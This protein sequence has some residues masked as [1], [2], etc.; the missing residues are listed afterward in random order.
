MSSNGDGSEVNSRLLSK[1][2]AL[3][4][5]QQRAVLWMGLQTLPPLHSPLPPGSPT[6]SAPAPKALCEPLVLT[7][8]P[9]TTGP[10]HMLFLLPGTLFLPLSPG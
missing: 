8:L 10:L 4:Q 7:K 1:R 9:S 5:F 6:L 3:Q 2:A